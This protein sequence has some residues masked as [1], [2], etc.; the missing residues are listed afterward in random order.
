MK[1]LWFSNRFIDN[2]DSG[3][4][5]TWLLALANLLSSDENIILGNITF[6]NVKTIEKTDSDNI[7]QWIVPSKKSKKNGLPKGDVKKE[8]IK[9]INDFQPDLIHVW[10][11]ESY[12]GTITSD[13]VND[14]PVLIEMQ[15]LKKTILPIYHGELTISE[16]IR[17][18]GFKE[19]LKFDTIWNRKQMFFKWGKIE[20]HIIKKH[21]YFST[22]SIWAEAKVLSINSKGVMFKNERALRSEFYDSPKWEYK[23]APILFTSMGY[24]APFKGLYTLIKSLEI[25][26]NKFPKVKLYIAGNFVL[27]GIRRDGYIN[28]ILNQIKKRNLVENVVWTGGLNSS[29][30]IDFL[31]KSSV[32]IYPSFNESYGLA[33]IESMV[34]GIP[35]I[36]AFN[37]GYG[38]NGKDEETL[39]FFSPGD[40]EMCAFQIIRMIEDKKLAL[41]L[42]ENARNFILDRNKSDKILKRQIEIYKNI[43]N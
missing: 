7:I 22:H 16:R 43:I 35:V 21:N 19:I 6:G 40:Y 12:W 24:P 41:Y 28:F 36:S 10:G 38:Y 5:G 9:I 15:G 17:C 30:I 23:N 4:T 13:V 32:A 29:E 34:V 3:S 27:N 11:T 25:L 8:L 20:D 14:F 33:L 26:K 18:I 37:G 39:L 42:S 31:M 2:N 1:I